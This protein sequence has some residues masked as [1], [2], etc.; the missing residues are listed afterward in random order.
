GVLW[1]PRQ[2]RDLEG[3]PQNTIIPPITQKIG[4]GPIFNSTRVSLQL[5]SS[6]NDNP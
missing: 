6:D 5:A 2:Y 4:G 1:S 3:I